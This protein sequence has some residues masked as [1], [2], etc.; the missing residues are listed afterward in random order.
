MQLRNYQGFND[1]QP[2]NTETFQIEIARE[3]GTCE[4]VV[5]A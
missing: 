2:V 3:L 4:V 5:D 1:V